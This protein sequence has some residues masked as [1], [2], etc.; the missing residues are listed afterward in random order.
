MIERRRS[1][2]PSEANDSVERIAFYI[3]GL[4]VAMMILACASRWWL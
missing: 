3:I 1:V 4:A 2:H